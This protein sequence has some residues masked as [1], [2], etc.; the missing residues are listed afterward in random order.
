MTRPREVRAPGTGRRL[1]LRKR[2]VIGSAALIALAAVLIGVVSILA[3]QGFL[4]NRLDTQLLSASGRSQ[5]ALDGRPGGNNQ[6][7]P[8]ARDFVALPGQSEALL[9]G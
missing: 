6:S 8:T 4:V 2:L 5:G 1:S 7:S 9:L 3:L